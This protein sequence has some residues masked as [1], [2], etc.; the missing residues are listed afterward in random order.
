VIQRLLLVAAIAWIVRWAIL[1]VG[2]ELE[3][4]RPPPQTAEGGRGGRPPLR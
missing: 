3:R 2:S 1:F 4:R